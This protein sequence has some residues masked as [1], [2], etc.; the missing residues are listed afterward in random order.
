ML[1][2]TIKSIKS[3][4]ENVHRLTLHGEGPR[5]LAVELGFR[6]ES[7]SH[8]VLVGKADPHSILDLWTCELALVCFFISLWVI[9][10]L[11]RV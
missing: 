4:S 2:Y 8:E 11:R 6:S 7:Q 10:W 3:I 1:S 9:L 5:T